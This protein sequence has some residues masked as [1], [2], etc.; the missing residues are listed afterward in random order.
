MI[1]HE[2]L[3]YAVMFDGAG[4]GQQLGPDEL[5]TPVKEG[6]FLWLHFDYTQ[7]TRTGSQAKVVCTVPML[8]PC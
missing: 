7:A 2:G 6:A 8:M 1:H 5:T 3:I 4:G